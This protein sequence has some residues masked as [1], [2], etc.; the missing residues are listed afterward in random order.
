MAP[1]YA[2]PD[3]ESE[4]EQPAK[5]T[6]STATLEKALRD[7]VGDVF[8]SGKREELTVK[9]VRL[10]AERKLGLDEGWFKGQ[11]E[12]KDESNRIIRDE[13]VCCSVLWWFGWFYY[14]VC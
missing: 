4:E 3:S 2:L 9:R 1:R 14:F 13:V 10:G 12:W 6:L 11:A 8:R 5:S 7:A